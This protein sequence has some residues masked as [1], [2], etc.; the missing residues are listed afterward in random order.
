[1]RLIGLTVILAVGLVL[2]PLAGEAQ[3]RAP[4]PRLGILRLNPPRASY[5][6]ASRETLQAVGYVEGD[7]LAVESRWAR[8][9]GAKPP[10][11]FYTVAKKR[12]GAP[13][14]PAIL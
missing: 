6:N 3:P 4:T 7:N 13:S 9:W 10:S 5:E 8:S 14:V 2:A 12:A 1:M 11:E